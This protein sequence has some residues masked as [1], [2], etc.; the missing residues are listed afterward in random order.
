MGLKAD[1]FYIA[2]GLAV[3]V[4]ILVTS[5]LHTWES[6]LPFSQHGPKL[7]DPRLEALGVALGLDMAIIYF[8]FIGV[9]RQS[10]TAKA[11]SVTA[12][13]LVWF[14]VMVSMLGL[15]EALKEGDPAR[16]LIGFVLS[17]FVPLSSLRV[18]QVLGELARGVPQ[19]QQPTRWERLRE[20]VAERVFATLMYK[21]DPSKVVKPQE[22]YLPT[23]E[24]AAKV[25]ISREALVQ[26]WRAGKLDSVRLKRGLSDRWEWCVE[27]LLNHYGATPL[28]PNRTSQP[29]N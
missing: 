18:G 5:F 12:M 2:W 4:L 7:V 19:G 1:R 20:A 15:P 14:A 17:L 27:D 26:D 16:N 10:R 3:Y 24:A 23:E 11:A 6:Y 22:T 9:L 8:S 13:L 21:F 25:G 29:A 28:P